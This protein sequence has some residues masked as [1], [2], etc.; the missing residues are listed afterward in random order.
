V[1]GARLSAGLL[2]GPAAAPV[3]CLDASDRNLLALSVS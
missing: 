3:A 2:R 1:I